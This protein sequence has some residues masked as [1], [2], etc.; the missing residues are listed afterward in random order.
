VSDND[1]LLLTVREAAALLRISQDLGYE[2]IRRNEL[3]A[4][5]LGRVIRV[6]RFAL[7]QWIARR[8]ERQTRRPPQWWKSIA[9]G[10]DTDNACRYHEG[11]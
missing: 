4:I 3:P 2:L 11:Q 6:P 7:E 10:I 8:P 1:A 9:R 5:R